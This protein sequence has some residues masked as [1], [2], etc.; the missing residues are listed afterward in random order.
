M[1]KKWKHSDIAQSNEKTKRSSNNEKENSFFWKVDKKKKR[2]N[3]IVDDDQ[4]EDNEDDEEKDSETNSISLLYE[5]YK[6]LIE[7]HEKKEREIERNLEKDKIREFILFQMDK[8]MDQMISMQANKKS[9]TNLKQ[10][11]KNATN[12]LDK[13][14][15]SNINQMSKNLNNLSKP[16]LE[17]TNQISKNATNNLDKPE[18]N[19]ISQMSKNL[20]N[21]SKPQLENTNQTS[22]NATDNL[23]KPGPSFIKNQGPVFPQEFLI[24]TGTSRMKSPDRNRLTS[25]VAAGVSK[26]KNNGQDPIQVAIKEKSKTVD[27]S[28]DT[29]RLPSLLVSLNKRFLIGGTDDY[30]VMYRC[31]GVH[32][33]EARP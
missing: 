11:S 19:N 13:P 26:M 29:Y 7:N 25:P 10:I 9:S 23:D 27:I 1:E 21:L 31:K 30:S 28:S 24:K 22:K 4:Q 5:K 12:N 14:E 18:P 16:Q 15:P 20:N 2:V 6:S 17:N 33:A 3:E 32:R 8:K